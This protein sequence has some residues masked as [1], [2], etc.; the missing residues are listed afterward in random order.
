LRGAGLYFRVAVSI[1]EKS[2]GHL[3]FSPSTPWRD[4][5][6]TNAATAT[7]SGCNTTNTGLFVLSVKAVRM[8]TRRL[9]YKHISIQCRML[10]TR[11]QCFAFL[12][13]YVICEI[14][15]A[16]T[17]ASGG[18]RIENEQDASPSAYSIFARAKMLAFTHCFAQKFYNRRRLFD[19]KCI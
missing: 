2:S 11:K 7:A 12:T 1:L 8:D 13:S 6:A 9:I 3:D 14:S 5:P 18:S 16:I 17:Y 4:S 15:E 19:S 10:A